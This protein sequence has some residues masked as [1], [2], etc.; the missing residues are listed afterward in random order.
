MGHRRDNGCWDVIFRCGFLHL[1]NEECSAELGMLLAQR[2]GS[3]GAAG[4]QTP[5]GPTPST[6]SGDT[7]CPLSVFSGWGGAHGF[8]NPTHGQ[9]FP[10]NPVLCLRSLDRPFTSALSQSSRRVV[11]QVPVE[12][13][14]VNAEWVCRLNSRRSEK[15]ESHASTDQVWR[16]LSIP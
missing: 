4:S 5:A 12:W 16:T 10:L 11:T 9:A 3:G 13:A 14:P 1:C 6:A 8:G 15:N 7:D 2:L